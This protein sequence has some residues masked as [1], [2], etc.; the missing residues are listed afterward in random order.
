MLDDGRKVIREL[1]RK[2]LL[3]ELAKV[4]KLFGE[5]SWRTGCYEEAARLFEEIT[6]SDDYVEFLTLPAYDWLTRDSRESVAA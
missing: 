3:E 6:A 1:F 2:L 5:E 4:R